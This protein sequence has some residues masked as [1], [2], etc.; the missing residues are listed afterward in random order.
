VERDVPGGAVSAVAEKTPARVAAALLPLALLVGLVAFLLTLGPAGLF[1]Q[2]FPPVE[3]LTVDRVTLTEGEITMVVTNG[4]PDPVTI[5]QVLVDEAYWQHEVT[6]ERTLDR[7]DTGTVTIPYPW[8]EGEAHEIVLISASGV[9]FSH[10]IEV[11]VES[12]SVDGR[13]LVTFALL[14]VYIG[15]VPVLLGMTWM[16]FLRTLSRRWIHFFMAF[17][18]GI[19]IF[20]GVETLVEAIEQ[21][22]GLPSALGGIGVV[23]VGAL[24]A[25]LLILLGSRRLQ[26]SG[27]ADR[28]LLVAY[29]VAAGIGLHNLGEGLAVGAAYRLGEVALG[30]FLVIGFAIHNTTEGLGIVS[31]L[32]ERKTAIRTLLVLGLIAGVPTI[33]GAWTGAFV[34]SPLVATIFLGIAAGAIA[35]VVYD[36]MKVVSDESDQGLLSVESLAGIVVGLV[37]MY[38]TGLLVT[39]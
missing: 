24:G 12:P 33:F 20:L 22:E 9:T 17:T 19:L 28:R 8:I 38:L 5:S 35:E 2:E 6:P 32:G 23:T 10:G 30:A 11:A 7:L 4:G 31:I 34:F 18:A 39:A 36:V 1:G 26:A 21:S 14:G 27:A 25:F 13:F 29:A 16:P 3:D 37:V 15:V